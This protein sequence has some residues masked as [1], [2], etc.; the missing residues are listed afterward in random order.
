MTVPE[1]ARSLRPFITVG[2]A[3][4]VEPTRDWYWFRC[5]NGGCIKVPILRAFNW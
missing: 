5:P 4:S 2:P 3:G 1:R